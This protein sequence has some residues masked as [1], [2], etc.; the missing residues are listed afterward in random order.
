[1][2]QRKL[3]NLSACPFCFKHVAVLW[4]GEDDEKEIELEDLGENIDLCIVC[5]MLNGGC[6]ASSGFR[7]SVLQA[8][9]A[10]EKRGSNDQNIGTDS[11]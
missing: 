8:I 1:M 7:Q 6:G 5:D 2:Y 4:D 10:W 3:P 11:L 9:A